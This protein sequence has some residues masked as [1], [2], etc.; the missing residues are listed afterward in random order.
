MSL[1]LDVMMLFVFSLFVFLRNYADAHYWQVCANVVQAKVTVLKYTKSLSFSAFLS[2]FNC[3]VEK[4]QYHM[5]LWRVNNFLFCLSPTKLRSVNQIT[6][7]RELGKRKMTKNTNFGEWM[8]CIKQPLST[9]QCLQW[10]PTRESLVSNY[11][12]VKSLEETLN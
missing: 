9:L 10:F 12:W 11:N 5:F 3:A 4:G 2:F 8:E 7:Y 6:E 1:F